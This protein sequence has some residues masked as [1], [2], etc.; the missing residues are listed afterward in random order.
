MILSYDKSNER[1]VNNEPTLFHRIELKNVGLM[2][3]GNSRTNKIRS[4]SG[5]T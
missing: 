3:Y 5:S 2:V 1:K 4:G